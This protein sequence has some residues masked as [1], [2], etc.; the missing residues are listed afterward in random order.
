M[1]TALAE[2]YNDTGLALWTQKYAVDDSVERLLWALA[3]NPNTNRPRLRIHPSCLGLISEMGKGKSP[4]PDG[5]TWMRH[6]TKLGLGP[7]QRAHDHACKALAYLLN[8]PYG[9]QA[10][11]TAVTMATAVSYLDEPGRDAS[12]DYVGGRRGR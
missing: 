11:E 5:G 1:P 7:P 8:G 9:Q 3:P 6:E 12:V 2:W 10:Y 4:V